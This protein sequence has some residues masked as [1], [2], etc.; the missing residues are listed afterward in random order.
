MF[1]FNLNKKTV[2]VLSVVIFF[3]AALGIYFTVNDN[4]N[5]ETTPSPTNSQ[6]N[7]DFVKEDVSESDSAQYFE[8]FGVGKL[9]VVTYGGPK[10][11]KTSILRGQEYALLRNPVSVG[12]LEL[13][14]S[15]P[16]GD[17]YFAENSLGE[18]ILY[19][20]GDPESVFG[21]NEVGIISELLIRERIPSAEYYAS[22][23]IQELAEQSGFS[24]IRDD[25]ASNR[26]LKTKYLKITNLNNNRQVIVEIDGRNSVEG[27]LYVS[28]ATR[29]ALLVDEGALGSFGL[30]IVDKENNSLGVV[31]R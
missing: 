27:T 24:P 17:Y 25:G 28:E 30:E 29:R 13:T 5:T 6:Q 12:G 11:I 10:S 16:Q 7:F 26:Y 31:R 21:Y 2:V 22:Y 4:N 14:V 18:K 23:P 9:K 1:K 3:F 20:E 19:T 8:S 15:N